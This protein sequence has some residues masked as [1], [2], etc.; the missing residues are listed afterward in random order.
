MS[1]F[2]VRTLCSEDFG[3]LRELEVAVFG[4]AGEDVLCPHHPH[5]PGAQVAA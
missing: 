2:T 3:A 5:L 4:T 1:R